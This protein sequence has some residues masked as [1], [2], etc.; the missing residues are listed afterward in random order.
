MLCG[1]VLSGWMPV[2]QK[3]YNM[4][5]K[6]I[7]L[8]DLARELALSDNAEGSPA[9]NQN[10]VDTGTVLANLGRMLRAT[11]SQDAIAV[12]NAIVE[13]AGTK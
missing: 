8:K 6:Q 4:K 13:R 5:T 9:Y 7:N 11:T 12:I 2:S 3:N 10:V 1:L